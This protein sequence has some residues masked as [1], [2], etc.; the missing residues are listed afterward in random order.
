MQSC[1]TEVKRQ[2]P[3]FT[4]CRHITPKDNRVT[5]LC[6]PCT[7]PLSY[8]RKKF[9]CACSHS[10]AHVHGS[11][12][13][14]GNFKRFKNKIERSGSGHYKVAYEPQTVGHPTSIIAGVPPVM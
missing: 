13:R 4:L 14:G 8:R 2:I 11:E 6:T 7:T 1:D 10:S 9:I 3:Q 12:F 5:T